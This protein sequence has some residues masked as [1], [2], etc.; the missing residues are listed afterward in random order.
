MK[1][2][3]AVRLVDPLGD[4]ADDDVVGDELARSMIALACWP[5][6]VSGATAARSMSPVESCDEAVPVDEPL[7]LGALAGARGPQQDQVH[8]LRR[9]PQ[10]RLS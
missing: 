10:L 7:G 6:A 9:S 8:R 4:D 1:P 5:S 2:L 3:P